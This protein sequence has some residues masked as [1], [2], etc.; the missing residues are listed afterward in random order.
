MVYNLLKGVP[1]FF[2]S[3]N[4]NLNQPEIWLLLFR[5]G[6]HQSQYAVHQNYNMNSN[7]RFNVRVYGLCIQ[8]NQVLLSDE[9]VFGMF[10]TKFPGGGLEY[11]EGTIECLKR[12]CLEEMGLEVKVTGHFY[13]TDFFQETRFFA[14]TQ[15]ISI[16]YTFELP[17]GARLK[18][19]D[20]PFDFEAIEGTQTFRWAPLAALKP[21]DLTFPVDQ[22]VAEMLNEQ[23]SERGRKRTKHS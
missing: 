8:N 10:M 2:I 13:T 20:T 3:T 9:Y 15:L 7:H 17:Q 19:A 6:E 16:Y 22:K 4:P 18:T 23:L 1:A 5:M 21:Q 14:N 11:G 12:E